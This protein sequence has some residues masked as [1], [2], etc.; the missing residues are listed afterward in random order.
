MGTR[1]I[2][3]GASI[4][5]LALGGK[6]AA[7]AELGG[8]GF[9]IPPWFVVSG[10]EDHELGVIAADLR[11]ACREICPDGRGVA[12]RSSAVGEDGG[13]QSYAG[14][15]ES[16]LDVGL[17]ELIDRIVAVRASGKSARVR[18][19]RWRV[20]VAG[21]PP[22]P[23]VL[24]QRM[25][26]AAWAGVAFA[27]D[28]V[29]GEASSAVVAVVR[30]LGDSLVRGERSGEMFRVDGEGRIVGSEVGAGEELS[31]VPGWVV[32][33]VAALARRVSVLRGCPQDIEWAVEAGRVYLLQ[34]RPITGIRGGG[35]GPSQVGGV[36]IWDNSN[37]AESYGGI[38]RPLTFS[39]ARGAYAEVY[40]SFC[41]LMGVPRGTV[42]ASDAV[43]SNMLGLI[44]GRVY[45]NLLNWYRLLAMLPGYAVN[46]RFMEQMMGVSAS[47]SD[48]LAAAVGPGPRGTRLGAWLRAAVSAVGLERQRRR[49]PRMMRRFRAR[50]DGALAVEAEGLRAMRAEE[51]AAHYRDLQRRLLRRWDAPIVN[52]FFAMVFHGLLRSLCSRWVDA[53]GE[54]LHNDLVR[55]VGGVISVEPAERLRRMGETAA[56]WPG[57]V[58][59]LRTGGVEEM[60][61]AVRSRPALFEQYEAYLARFADRCLEELKLES[62]TLAD[63]PTSLLRSI[64]HMGA[65]VASGGRLAGGG[66]GAGERAVRV[67]RERLRRRPVRR[68]VFAWVLRNARARVRDREN[69]RFERTR[70]FG[71]V[72]RVFLE[73][74]ARLV[75]RS[76][77]DDGRHVFMLEV[78]EV[79]GY[80]EGTVTTLD[81]RSLVALRER[82]YAAFEGEAPPP[83]RFSTR[84]MVHPLRVDDRGAGSDGG[85]P[86]VRR[87]VG[88][89]AGVVRGRVRIIR[90]PRGA[91][92]GEGEVLVAERTDPGWVMLFPAAA[93][94]LVERGSLLSHSAIV[95]R[96]LGIPS[97]VS[98]AGL[99]GW[100]RDGDEVELDGSAGVVRLLSREGSGG[101]VGP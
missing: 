81:L 71:H 50:L 98:I 9:A 76:V 94:I 20:G 36:V 18:E 89:C 46:R 4:D 96:E 37:I 5:P 77:I 31:G 32:S 1:L 38:T 41:G 86:Q 99:T 25:V 8:R 83:D 75:D 80:I 28:P 27:V 29:T 49:L 88:C 19:Y 26:R 55:G 66:E 48:E 6:A 93:G 3:S 72:R 100:L 56:A 62:P 14:Q 30:G 59:V 84:G 82:E 17:D 10:G 61:A 42:E 2:M 45:Y 95:S 73:V 23:A 60:V 44:R 58:S 16:F 92:L 13:E 12:V 40:R 33:E 51:L 57:V 85:D 65:R 78:E 53:G 87:G 67:V 54:S 11:R 79:L 47:L 43:F 52:D 63:D 64:G 69:L 22:V 21:E 101:R 68:V 97:V 39:F 74:G 91:E 7:L 34:A 70:V 24:V 35:A 15:L 90:E